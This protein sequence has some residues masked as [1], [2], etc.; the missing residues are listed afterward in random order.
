MFKAGDRI[1]HPIRGAG[2]VMDVEERDW[3]GDNDTYYTIQLLGSQASKL[4]VPTSAAK[5]LGLRRAISRSKLK[6]LWGVLRS[7]PRKLP[8]EHKKRYKLLKEKLHA[9]DVFQIAEVVRDMAWRQKS[10]GHLNTVGK[11]MYEEGL[12][13]LAGEIAAVQDIEPDDAEVEVRTQLRE[14]LTPAAAA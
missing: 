10:R 9:G 13:L 8:K 4:I 2:I 7:D 11:R 1:V 14:S 5:D 6:K 12:R 3:H